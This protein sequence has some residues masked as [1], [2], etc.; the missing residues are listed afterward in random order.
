FSGRVSTSTLTVTNEC[1]ASAQVLATDLAMLPVRIC[2]FTGSVSMTD[3]AA[4]EYAVTLDLSKGAANG[5]YN[6]GGCV[7]SGTLASAPAN[8]T[9][10]VTLAGED[11]VPGDYAIAGFSS[12]GTLL[13]GWTVNL[14][15]APDGV[16][17]P[18]GDLN[19]ALKVRVVR[20]QTGLWLRCRRVCG[21]FLVI[22]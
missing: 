4:K 15:N 20:G 9:V 11:L 5:D 1:A 6:A 2:G 22:E 18:K 16:Y 17:N 14:A 7:G 10:N 13:S 12:G 8:G 3:T 21:L 19:R